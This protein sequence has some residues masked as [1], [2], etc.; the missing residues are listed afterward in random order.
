MK[1]RSSDGAQKNPNPLRKQRLAFFPLSILFPRTWCI[2]FCCCGDSCLKQNWVQFPWHFVRVQS[3]ALMWLVNA[4]NK[5]QHCLGILSALY[6]QKMWSTLYRRRLCLHLLL[7]TSLVV[8]RQKSPKYN[9]LPYLAEQYCGFL[10][11]W[12]HTMG[13]VD[14]RKNNKSSRDSKSATFI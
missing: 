12:S 7:V 13:Y 5:W 14:F 4:I 10:L 1:A 2:E 8:F 11:P 3:L 6:F 9:H